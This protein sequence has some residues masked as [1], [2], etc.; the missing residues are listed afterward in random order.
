MVQHTASA[1]LARDAYSLVPAYDATSAV[2]ARAASTLVL[3]YLPAATFLT[4]AALVLAY[5]ADSTLLP[6]HVPHM[7]AALS[8]VLAYASAFTTTS[9]PLHRLRRRSSLHMRPSLHSE[10]SP[11]I[12]CARTCLCLHA[13][14]LLPPQSLHM[15]RACLCSHMLCCLHTI[16]TCGILACDRICCCLRS[17]AI[18]RIR[19]SL[20]LLRVRLC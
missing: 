20:H 2:F 9:Q 1:L 12:H 8:L 15:L 19:L 17:S 4:C 11:G 3:A 13:H 6:H 5:A 7:H 10:S 18:R 16:F 14:V